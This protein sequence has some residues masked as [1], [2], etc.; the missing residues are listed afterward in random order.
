MDYRYIPS[1]DLCSLI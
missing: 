1:E